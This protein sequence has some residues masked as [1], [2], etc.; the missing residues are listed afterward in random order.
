MVY[1][2]E[3]FRCLGPLPKD[4]TSPSDRRYGIPVKELS[5]AYKGVEQD[6]EALASER[7]I[8]LIWS[9]AFACP[10]AFP[11]DLQYP[12]QVQLAPLRCATIA[13]CQG[14][15]DISL[16]IGTKACPLADACRS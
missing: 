13:Q 9:R 15:H 4:F 11:R 10:V 12:T 2:C 14:R 3:R 7:H 6:L 5:D 16:I 8:Y 1:P